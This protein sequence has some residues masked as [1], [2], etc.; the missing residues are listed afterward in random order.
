MT[1]AHPRVAVDPRDCHCARMTTTT[2]VL[3]KDACSPKS[4]GGGLGEDGRR[5]VRGLSGLARSALIHA[6]CLPATDVGQWPVTL[7]GDGVVLLIHGAGEGE[8]TTVWADAM[9][10]DINDVIET[11]NDGR[12][13][14]VVAWDWH[15]RSRNRELA[16]VAAPT[17]AARS[18]SAPSQTRP[19][20]STSSPTA[21]A[22]SWCTVRCRRWPTQM[23][24]A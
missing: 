24:R 9:A 23:P 19:A 18:L 10:A 6:G 17:K 4:R 21:R 1:A 22:P 2:C 13:W 8:D 5:F 14:H 7:D 3:A 16:A 12:R 20:T 15:E 11:I